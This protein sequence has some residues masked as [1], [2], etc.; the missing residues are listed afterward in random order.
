MGGEPSVRSYVLGV[1][2]GLAFAGRI[3]VGSLIF[4]RLEMHIGSVHDA[5]Q[6]VKSSYWI[7]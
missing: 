4:N 3:Y 5:E 7:C 1:P 6:E 2:H